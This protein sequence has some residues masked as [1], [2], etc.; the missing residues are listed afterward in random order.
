MN[1]DLKKMLTDWNME[2]LT[3]L[4]TYQLLPEEV[5]KGMEPLMEFPLNADTMIIPLTTRSSW[6]D[7]PFS[8]GNMGNYIFWGASGH[9]IQNMCLSAIGLGLG[10]TYNITP[11]MDNRREELLCDYLGIPRSWDPMGI[12]YVGVPESHASFG[13]PSLKELVYKEH[14]GNPYYE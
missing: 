7:Y 1:D 10:T 6:L 11:I 9:S 12:L 4:K 3:L 14:W 13:R 5:V 8:T 2:V